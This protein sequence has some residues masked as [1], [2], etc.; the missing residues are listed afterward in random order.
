M[1]TLVTWLLDII[2][3]GSIIWFMM[4]LFFFTGSIKITG[5]AVTGVICLAFCIADS[6][7]NVDDS[8]YKED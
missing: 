4:F 2:F 8:F 7:K 5:L 6:G 3:C 1:K